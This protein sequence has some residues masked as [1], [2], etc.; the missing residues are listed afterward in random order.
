MWLTATAIDSTV[1]P[2]FDLVISILSWQQSSVAV[3]TYR[4]DNKEAAKLVRKIRRH[5][6]LVHKDKLGM[7]QKLMGGLD[8]DAALLASSLVFNTMT[9]VVTT[10]FGDA[11]E[12]LDG[13]D[14]DL[15]M[16]RG[17]RLA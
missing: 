5:G 2:L 9:Q 15:E 4:S 6:F 16:T 1:V 12:Q 11:D 13:I 7:V 3:V 17:G 8:M 14:A 10:K